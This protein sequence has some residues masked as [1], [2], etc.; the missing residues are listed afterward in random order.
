MHD[1]PPLWVYRAS[2]SLSQSMKGTTSSSERWRSVRVLE[3]VYFKG[4]ILAIF[5]TGEMR[6][7]D[8]LTRV[9]QGSAVI[10]TEHSNSERGYLKLFAEKVAEATGTTV[11]ASESD[12]DPLSLFLPDG[13]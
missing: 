8:V 6:H 4:C 12:R 2:G 13:N 9:A 7:H 1:L 5:L 10:L 11:F 3:E